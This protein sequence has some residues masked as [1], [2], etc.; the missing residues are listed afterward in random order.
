MLGL[1]TV[2]ALLLACSAQVLAV[3]HEFTMRFVG[4]CTAARDYCVGK[5]LS[6]VSKAGRRK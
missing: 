5:G 2:A 3:D 1:T 6:Q 4:Q